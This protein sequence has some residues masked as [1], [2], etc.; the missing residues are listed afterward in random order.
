MGILVVVFGDRRFG[1]ANWPEVEIDD[2]DIVWSPNGFPEETNWTALVARG[3]DEAGGRGFVTELA[4]PTAALAEL[5]RAAPATSPE[6]E[7]ASMALLELLDAHPYLTRLYTRL[8][9][10]EM[11]VDPIFRRHDGGD[12]DRMR[13]LSRIVAGHDLC[14][15]ER[16]LDPCEFSSCGAGG[17]CRAVAMVSGISTAA[18]ECEAR[19]SARTTFA[20]NGQPIVVCQDPALSFL[21]P[22]DRDRPGGDPL[23]D[24]CVG[25]DCGEG[26]CVPVNLTPTCRCAVGSVAIGWMDAGARRTRCVD[27]AVPVP[28]PIRG[29]PGIEPPPPPP[30]PPPVLPAGGGCTTTPGTGSGAVWLALLLL[31]VLRRRRPGA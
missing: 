10:E 25:F 1:P 9:P 19:F 17:R 18:C 7:R 12:V 26:S 16:P 13:Q 28:D 30:T 4:E 27:P 11:T 23:P 2:A 31:A 21:R 24:P 8:S 6:Q 5:V 22:G 29:M 3:V 15:L 20:P 14:A